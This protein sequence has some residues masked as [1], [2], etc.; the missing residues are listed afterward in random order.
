MT[1]GGKQAISRPYIVA[2]MTGLLQ[3]E[4]DDRMLEIGT[5]SGYQ[6]AV[7]AELVSVVYSIE[8]IPELARR[9]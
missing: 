1:R 9:N 4:P 8:I 2:L 3:P 5:G 7:A 6:G